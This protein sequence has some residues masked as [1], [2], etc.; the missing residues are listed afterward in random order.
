MIRI[1]I[2]LIQPMEAVKVVRQMKELAE[3]QRFGKGIQL[4]VQK[5]N[6][7]KSLLG[8][9]AFLIED[10]IKIS[11]AKQKELL[12]SVLDK[13]TTVSSE[14]GFDQNK[15]GLSS[16]EINW[17]LTNPKPRWIEY[18]IFRQQLFEISNQRV[19]PDFPPYVLIEPTSVCNLRCVMCF[20]VDK[21]FTKAPYM[22]MIDLQ[23]FK[24][25]VDECSAMGTKAITLASRGEPTLH[26][27]F[28][29]M[30][31]YLS[32]K[33]FMEIKINTNGTKLSENICHAILR[34][35]VT[36]V[37]FS[38]DA[39]TKDTYEKI[40][41]RGKFHEVVR[42][43][44]RFHRIRSTYK[45]SPTITRISGVKV[46]PD[47]SKEQ[48]LRFWSERVDEVT[49]KDALPR[50]DSY[51]NPIDETIVTPCR[52]LFDRL[53]VWYDGTVN[54]CDFDYKSYL[55]TGNV[56]RNTLSEIWHGD[57]YRRLREEHLVGH[58]VSIN[59]CDK[60]PIT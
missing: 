38:V 43:I 16:Q 22:G 45:N 53:Y 13:C 33:K 59:P 49:I 1:H 11:P 24:K 18:L 19:V 34:A 31:D 2:V 21:T 28:E 39:G 9:L 60:C 32:K 25:V 17:L 5:T 12:L 4:N 23:L 26:P 56:T 52:Q 51:N 27:D 41:V 30:L 29:A 20:Q 6:E 44:E 50:W 15:S 7:V 42:N 46:M 57:A 48:M 36:S 55:A 14:V 35:K 8:D 37:V 54:P 47:Q 3:K 58:R 10:T 40:R